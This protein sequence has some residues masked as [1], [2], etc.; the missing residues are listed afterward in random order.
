MFHYVYLLADTTGHFYIGSRTCR[1][2]PDND[3]YSGSGV[4]ARNMKRIGVRLFKVILAE[5][6]S[7]EMACK[8]ESKLIEMHIGDS[9]C[10]NRTKASA[11]PSFQVNRGR[12][13]NPFA[14]LIDQGLI[15]AGPLALFLWMEVVAFSGDNGIGI[16]TTV[17]ARR[18]NATLEECDAALTSISTKIPPSLPQITKQG[19]I[20]KRITQL[21]S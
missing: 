10:M 5:F 14:P 6:D 2:E 8:H 17:L 13:E 19:R 15:F 21:C 20:W 3:G 11:V 16:S 1:I 7:R 12:W 18:N 4:W 9:F